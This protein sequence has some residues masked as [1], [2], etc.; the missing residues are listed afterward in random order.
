MADSSDLR[1]TVA[2]SVWLVYVG[3]ALLAFSILVWR[4]STLPLF[5]A[6][7]N[8]GAGLMLVAVI[9]FVAGVATT[10]TGALRWVKERQL[11]E[12]DVRD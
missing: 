2:G 7:E 5:S 6:R 9:T 1:P 3:I 10:A 11:E 8:D 12:S 4:M